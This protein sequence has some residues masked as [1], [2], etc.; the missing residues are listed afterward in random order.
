M[1]NR[2]RP[3]SQFVCGIILLVF[4]LVIFYYPLLVPSA[5]SNHDAGRFIFN[6]LLVF[7]YLGVLLCFSKLKRGGDGLATLFVLLTLALISCFSLN[8]EIA[9]FQTSA[10]WWAI[11]LIV[12]CVNYLTLPF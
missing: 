11:L 5:I 6:Y 12:C 8:R 9:I 10:T 7:V 1:L 3:D 4:S 2:L